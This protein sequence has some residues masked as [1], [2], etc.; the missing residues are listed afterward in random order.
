MAYLPAWTDGVHHD[1]SAMYL[2]NPLPAMGETVTVRLRLPAATPVTR[3]FI[4]AAVDGE[5]H[6]A[7]LHIEQTTPGAVILAGTLTIQQPRTDYRFKLMTDAGAYIYNAMGIS[8]ADSPE[9]YDFTLLADYPAPLWVRECVFYQIFPERFHNGNPANDVL[10]NAWV[11]E[12]KATRRRNWGEPP[13]PWKEGR[14]VDFYGGDLEGITQ[15]LSYLQRLGINALYLTPIFVASSN[16]RYDINDFHHVDPHVGGD[17]A[18]AA[19]R[20]ALDTAAMRLMLDITPNHVGVEHVWFKQAQQDASA[21]EATFFFK[22]Q[23]TGAY[24]TWLG[25][26]SLIKLNWSSQV[27]R[28]RMYRQPDSALRRW[29]QPPYRIDAWRLDVANMTGNLRA[30][31]LDHDVWQEMRPHLKGDNPDLYLLGEYFPDGTPHTQGDELDAAMNYAGFNIPVRRW[32]GGEDVGVQDGQPYGDPNL[33]PAEA[34]A[35]QWQRFMAAVPY[36]ITLQQFTQLDSH[37]TTRILNVCGGDKALV[38]LGVALLM[39]FPG[40]PCVYYGT[41]IGL[42]GGKDPDNR[43]CMPWEED[44]WDLDLLTYHQH[45]IGIRRSAPAL[46]HGG[47]QR[48]LA[49]GDVIAFLREAPQQTLLFVG[50]RAASSR[51]E[52]PLAAAGLAA[53]VVLRDL[54]S[55]NV[56][57]ATAD[58]L[59]LT[60]LAAGT[61]LLLEVQPVSPAAQN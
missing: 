7:P 37:D 38:K 23:T 41:E 55:G 18:L 56:Y 25:V 11:R 29:L 15:K 52:V 10:D 27:L 31:Q 44:A 14:S 28:D 26:S 57:T 13:I 30:L 50:S 24:E 60:G 16:H 39:A 6:M 20:A 1:G 46:A 9:Y 32:L 34:M 36:V 48:L 21:P 2:S 42:A 17:A 61:A 47:F 51:V 33:L 49:E 19:L 59:V 12:G 45:L 8:R 58:V 54:I 53:G 22:D 5:T 3:A 43:R 40:V 35:L 4:R